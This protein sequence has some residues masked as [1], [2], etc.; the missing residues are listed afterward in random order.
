MFCT[1]KNPSSQVKCFKNE[2][3]VYVC[4]LAEYICIFTSRSKYSPLKPD[5]VRSVVSTTL[6]MRARIRAIGLCIYHAAARRS[7]YSTSTSI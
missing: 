6:H 7:R 2:V 4:G 1:L 3:A 5:N